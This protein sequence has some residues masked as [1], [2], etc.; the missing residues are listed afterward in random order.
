MKISQDCWHYKLYVF[1]SQWSAAWRADD[2]YL[3]AGEHTSMIGLCPYMRMILIWGPL[4]I[5][6]NIIPLG[7]VI[8][9]LFLFPASA[10]GFMGI[11]WLFFWLACIVAAFFGI[12]WLKDFLS[13]REEKKE[14]SQLPPHPDDEEVEK[15][16]G[17]WT[18]V[19]EYI[20]AAKTKV[21]PVLE[22]EEDD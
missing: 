6:S 9:V 7:G 1:M 16:T 21:C 17:F 18:I 10:N 20:I 19:K 14:R 5:L 8:G 11:F 3:H 22:I 2:N 12:G 4:A 13:A 15:P